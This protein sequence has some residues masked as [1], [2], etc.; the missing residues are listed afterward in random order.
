M[1]FNID[2]QFKTTLKEILLVIS[3]F[4]IIFLHFIKFNLLNQKLIKEEF[5]LVNYL[6]N[7][8][9]FLALITI[10]FST[11]DLG[12]SI[13]PM[14]RPKWDSKLITTGT[15]RILRHPMYYSLILISLGLFIKSFTIY[16]L[17]LFIF[18]IF[19]ICNKINIEEK[20]LRKKF[21]NYTSYKKKVKI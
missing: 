3:Q 18:L 21:S 13:S 8:L 11:K 2:K 5:L 9:I 6:G 12:K 4:I 20:Y 19:I 1:H 7:F 17:I 15:Y 10:L 14:P 16:N